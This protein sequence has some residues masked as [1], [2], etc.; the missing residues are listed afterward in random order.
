VANPDFDR[1]ELRR[2]LDEAKATVGDVEVPVRA[3]VEN[4]RDD[5]ARATAGAKRKIEVPVEAKFDRDALRRS[6]EDATANT[7]DPKQL[8]Q[9]LIAADEEIRKIT[10][11]PVMVRLEIDRNRL[12]RQIAE[13]TREIQSLSIRGGEGP[14]VQIRLDRAKQQLAGFLLELDAVDSRIV[15]VTAQVELD[16]AKAAAE[17]DAFRALESA[18]S[19]DLSVRLDEAALQRTVDAAS[20]ALRGE[21]VRNPILFKLDADEAELLRKIDEARG[22]LAALS[23]DGARITFDADA[24]PVLDKIAR[25][26]A[27]LERLSAMKA[28]PEVNAKVAAAQADLAKFTA[29]LEALKSQNW[30]ARVRA[31]IESGGVDLARFRTELDAIDKRRVEAV[32]ALDVNT[33]GAAAEIDAFIARQRLRRK[34]H[35]D[36][37]VDTGTLRTLG[38][39]IGQSVEDIVGGIASTTKG[40]FSG[41]GSAVGDGFDEINSGFKDL[42]IDLSDLV[43]TALNLGAALL[44]ISAIGT[45]VALAGAAITQAWGLASTAIGAIPG[46]I[47]LVGVSAGVVMLGLD[48]IKKAAGSI[49]PEFDKLK[50]SVSATFEKGLTPAFKQLATIIPGLT[51]DVNRV[52]KAISITG[53]NLAVLITSSHG[54]ELLETIFKRTSDSI[55]AMNP[56]LL[57]IV[58]TFLVLAS[59][60]SVFD[61]LTQAVN[62]FGAAFQNAVTSSI[63]SGSFDAAMRGLSVTLGELSRGFTD[64]VKNGITVF[65]NSAPGLNAALSS[66]TN[67]FNKFDWARL[68]KAA[69][70]VFTGLASAISSI[71]QGQIDGITQGFEAFGRAINGPQFQAGFQAIIDLIRQLVQALP[72]MVSAISRAA[73][74]LSGFV[75]VVRGLAQLGPGIF[76]LFTGNF[77]RGL[78]EITSA[79]DT[80]GPLMASGM[81]KIAQAVQD[82]GP[83]ITAAATGAV[84]GVGPAVSAG[85]STVSASA[86]PAMMDLKAKIASGAIDAAS[87]IPAGFKGVGTA[88]ATALAPVTPAAVAAV[89]SVNTA[90]SGEMAKVPPAA[91]TA[92]APIQQLQALQGMRDQFTLAAADSMHAMSVGVQSGMAEVQQQF[93]TGLDTASSGVNSSFTLIGQGFTVGMAGLAQ[94][95]AAGIPA[96]QTAFNFENVGINVQTTFIGLTA[97]FS[98]GMAS[99]AATVTAGMPLIQAAFNFT[100]IG[101]QVG[102]AFQGLV[103]S[104]TLGMQSF[105]AT[106]TAGMVLVQQAF[107]TGFTTS[108]TTSITTGFAGLKVATDAGMLT[109]IDAIRLGGTLMQATLHV[110]IG[111]MA[112]DVTTQFAL[113]QTATLDGMQSIVDTISGSMPAV[114]QAFDMSTLSLT[115]GLAFQ[116][117]VGT[118]TLGMASI[119]VAVSTGMAQASA[120]MSTGMAGMA[121]AATAGMSGVTAAI[122]AGMAIAI[123]AIDSAGRL[124]TASAQASMAGFGNAIRA[125]MTD[126]TA[127]VNAGATA[128][129]T[130]FTQLGT[131]IALTATQSMLLFANAVRIGMNQSVAAVTAGVAAMLGALRAGSGQFF[132]VGV[133]M[134]SGLRSGILSQAGSI[135]AAAAAV[136]AGAI[137]AARAAANVHSPSRVFV[138]IGS[139]MGEGLAVGM[140]SMAPRVARAADEMVSA[141]TDTADKISAAFSGSQLSS[142]LSA[143]IEHSFGDANSTISTKD[144]VG[145]LRKLN[146]NVDQS[147]YLSAIVTL[148]QAIVAQGSGSGNA[149]MGAQSSR[150]AAELG[151]F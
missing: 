44:R 12:Q 91:E 32:L 151:A 127:S 90:V 40:I 142:D 83:A 138:E 47:A 4:F 96:I 13:A 16:K 78:M 86:V 128:M 98:L 55:L 74:A 19:V 144:V 41:I 3:N 39:R 45:G 56:G 65:A 18:E 21:T 122:Q 82:G 113:I 141:A 120:S 75:D 125:G 54:V 133:Q 106:V 110:A 149:A 148:L 99:L 29:E 23:V 124:I 107:T 93:K 35:L 57:K 9:G 8:L 31:E 11:D 62:D 95:V 6:I 52:A 147:S 76:D 87:A 103:G 126:A 25:V 7:V 67:F 101:T 10:R 14:E 89:G 30:E 109:I 123:S 72:T 112:T 79:L 150:Q 36:V 69:S 71:P 73:I 114:T 140:E 134:M 27:D 102:L 145:Q 116:S 64:L 5:I 137:A 129:Q 118:F 63:A 131:Q 80:A 38:A 84:A 68:G 115:V 20:S 132:S 46:A 77:G 117:L 58:D 1:D 2:Q 48:G 146:G 59:Q 105:A 43:K 15:T 28:T 119:S 85:L 135:A 60:K 26:R 53:T 49:K 61:L 81:A 130:R 143:K 111:L 92:L 108:L 97:A 22:H 34:I 104:V 100:N 121:A 70:D 88:T 139:F 37:E 17:L 136:V 24:T 51:D 33:A 50:A 94:T 66:I 42:G